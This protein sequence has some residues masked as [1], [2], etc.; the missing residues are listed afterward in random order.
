MA[1]LARAADVPILFVLPVR[2]LK[3][4][5]YLRFHMTPDEIVEGKLDRWRAFYQA[6]CDAKREGRYDAALLDEL[7]DGVDPCGENGEF[8]TFCTAAPGFA[9]PIAVTVGETVERGGFVY[10]D[11]LPA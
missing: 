4:S 10:A 9:E 2:N 11:V 3:Q 7:P 6:G 5:F 1:S 8:H